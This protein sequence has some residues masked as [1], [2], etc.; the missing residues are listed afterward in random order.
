M[1]GAAGAG[2]ISAATTLSAAILSLL[3]EREQYG[4]AALVYPSLLGIIAWRT[5]RLS[6]A[7]SLVGVVL[8]AVLV[9]VSLVTATSGSAGGIFG[10]FAALTGYRGARAARRFRS[11]T[12]VPGPNVDRR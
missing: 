12:A 4:T 8:A 10:L 11:R 2:L 9:A 6:T 1:S 7:W 5:W 3:I